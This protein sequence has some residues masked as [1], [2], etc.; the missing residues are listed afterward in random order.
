L[1]VRGSAAR[2]ICHDRNLIAGADDVAYSLALRAAGFQLCVANDALIRHRT[3]GE[4]DIAGH[5]TPA[6]VIASWQSFYRRWGFV[7]NTAASKIGM[8]L[9]EFIAQVTDL[10]ST[11]VARDGA[12]A[13]PVNP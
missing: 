4:S 11:V 12:G 5:R 9:D 6:A 8:T 1:A 10:A 7:R 13:E 2:Q 3:L